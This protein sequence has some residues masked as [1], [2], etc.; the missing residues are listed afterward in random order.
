[1]IMNKNNTLALLIASGLLTACATSSQ[2]H[3]QVDIPS[4]WRQS[5]Q[6]AETPVS[7]SWWRSFGSDELAALI[8]EARRQNPDIETAVARVEQARAQA[9]IAGA[10]LLPEVSAGLE[11]ERVGR[12][13]G[14]GVA[15]G[16]QYTAG[17][18]ASYEVDFWG[19]N[20]AGRDAARA[21]LRAS[22]FDRDTV[23]LTVTAGVASAWLQAVGLRE[24]TAIAMRSLASARRLLD[25]VEARARAGAA[26]P[27]ELAQQRGVV[28]AQQRVL[29][30]VRQ[31]ADEAH[32]ALAI[33]LG[34]SPASLSLATRETQAIAIPEIGA[35]L[36]S[37]LLAR[38]PDIARAEARLASADA[39]ISAARAAMFPQLILTAD[40]SGTSSRTSTLFD[41]PLYT[42]A[43]G[44][45]APIF[46]AGRLAAGRDLAEAQRAEM[47]AAYRQAIIAAFGDVENALSA[48]HGT[49][50]Q[51][52][53]QQDALLQAQ[54]ALTLAESRYRAG[55]ETSL[56]LLD[57][58]R[59]LYAAQDA[60]AQLRMA[61]LQASVSLYRALGGGWQI[62]REHEHEAEQGS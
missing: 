33:L 3:V 30:A 21:L 26:T 7:Q 56:V 5:D 25:L 16:T 58:Q 11:A 36:P 52:R 20:R 31:Q 43:A 9:R 32:T 37:T 14:D 22:V 59:T 54:R 61:R 4:Q 45:T 55:A 53:A 2:P 44:L 29:A 10:A 18:S 28:A 47:L 6:T 51:V 60:A 41:N 38:R 46:N 1:M 27:L 13:G 24:R 42:V 40:V 57:A 8:D 35:G 49:Q 23:D 15:S 17:F 12:L 39:S 62:E 34:R 48:V 50:E 19:R